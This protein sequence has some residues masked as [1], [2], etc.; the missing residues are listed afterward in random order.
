MA[1]TGIYKIQSISK[2]ERIYIGSAMSIFDR[3]N[4]HKSDFKFNRRHAIQFQ[5]HYN[6][7]SETDLQ[8]SIVEEFKFQSKQHL[9]A[10]EQHYIDTY[11]PYFN[12]CKIAGSPLGYKHTIESNKKKSEANIRNGHRPPSTKGMKHSAECGKKHAEVNK[13][14]G[15]VPPSRKGCKWTFGSIIK[16]RIQRRREKIIRLLNNAA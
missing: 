10:R 8:F 11:K 6:K 5:R 7:Y 2:P 1:T 9:L 14:L 16:R 4:T 3:W 13:R 12:G 15:I